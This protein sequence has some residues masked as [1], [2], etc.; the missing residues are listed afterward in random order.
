[1]LLA[2][3]GSPKAQE[4]LYVATYLAGQWS[5]P[6]VVITVVEK[7]RDRLHLSQAQT[8]L[9]AHGLTATFVSK[10]GPVAETI[11][12]TAAEHGCRL[13][14]LGGFGTGP[15]WDVVLGSVVDQVLGES[16]QPILICR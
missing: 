1:V 11:I 7:E 15:V 3:D 10:Q 16:K 8:Y 14:I 12:T 5:I 9:E 2:Y 4:G 6:L 13:I